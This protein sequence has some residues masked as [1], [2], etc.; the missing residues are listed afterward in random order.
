LAGRAV[1][2]VLIIAVILGP[3]VVFAVGA[4]AP[5]NLQPTL[6]SVAAA[7]HL[8]L[9]TAVRLTA[10]DNDPSYDDVLATQYNALTPEN[11]M[12]WAT[13]EPSPHAFD[14]GPADALVDFAEAN[15]MVVR[16][17]N[18]VWQEQ[19]PSWLTDGHWNRDQLISLLREH[20]MR[21]VGHYRGR[22]AQWDVVNEPLA[23]DG[24]LRPDIWSEGI[25]PDYIA[26][27]FDWAHQADPRAELF[28]NEYG[29]E[30]GGPKTDAAYRL[31][32]GLR[33]QGVP[34]EGIGLQM[35]DPV[36]T[37][38]ELPALPV[39]MARLNSLGVDVAV[40]EMDVW[41]PTASAA[42]DLGAQ[43]AYYR[44]VLADCLAA[45]RCS[46]FSTWGFTDRYSWVPGRFPGYTDALPWDSE[47]RAKP[48][49]L[50]IRAELARGNPFNR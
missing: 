30:F 26:M 45:A 11:E 44:T 21:V 49:A 35:H 31:V 5:G 43:A 14:F 24:T 50:A 32:A 28:L 3:V 13:I 23:E 29:I 36:E 6:R 34:V 10:V 47:L 17:H 40:T 2:A 9:G 46:T 27:A 4:A 48:A 18:L 39:V 25:G 38:P 22:V 37:S 20:I 1:R 41:L 19:N 16:G 7:R 42:A 8:V 12:K 15:G 33:A